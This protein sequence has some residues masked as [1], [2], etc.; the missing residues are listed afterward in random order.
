MMA[1]PPGGHINLH[2]GLREHPYWED[3]ERLRAWIDV[4][5]M[6]AWKRHRRLVGTAQV[7]L[8]RG[9]FIAS[10]RFLSTRWGWS[11]GRV[12]RFLEAAEKANEIEPAGDTTDGTIYVVVKYDDYQADRP[13]N[14]TR[15]RTSNGPATDQREEGKEGKDIKAPSKKRWRFVP[16]D[17]EPNQSHRDMAKRLG[18]DL[19]AE[20][21][22]YRDY[23]YDKPKSDPDRTFNTWL[24]NANKFG[25]A[26]PK[27]T[28]RSGP[29]IPGLN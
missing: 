27:D 16:A 13:T 15:N 19:E 25:G 5:F 10:E 29:Y 20:A 9:Q 17:W 12:R 26:K 14:G 4:L 22:A 1:A 6:A 3:P 2:R 28:P 7:Q 11:R 23:E 24:R 21:E 8:E 18:L